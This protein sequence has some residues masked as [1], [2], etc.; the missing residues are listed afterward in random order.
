M[1]LDLLPIARQFCRDNDFN[2]VGLIYQAMLQV[3]NEA[4]KLATDMASTKADA[5]EE[6]RQRNLN[7]GHSR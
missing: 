1:K 2:N 4:L 7:G 5:L 6:Q 3:A